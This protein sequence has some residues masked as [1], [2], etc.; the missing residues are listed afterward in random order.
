MGNN[1]SKPESGADAATKAP[2]L[3]RAEKK[4][5]AKAAK[6]APAAAA[7]ATTPATPAAPPPPPPPPVSKPPP[8]A[9]QPKPL[10]PS[11]N[12][13]G[14]DRYFGLENFGN[15]CYANSV[16]QALYFC[17]PFRAKVLEHAILLEAEAARLRRAR[18]AAR[19]HA[20]AEKERLEREAKLRP[21]TAEEK[22]AEKAAEKAEKER[23]AAAKAA[24]KAAKEAA[25][26]ADEE[27]DFS[28]PRGKDAALAAAEEE[29]A[30][31][32]KAKADAERS[33]IPLDENGFPDL[34]AEEKPK[35]KDLL[36]CLADV[37]S[38]I[39]FSKRR[40]GVVGPKRFVQRL[41][42]DN[43]LFRSYMHQDA[44]E[45]Y[46][47]LLE[48]SARCLEQRQ[49]R[50]EEEDRL[51]SR[52]DEQERRKAEERYAAAV[53]EH[54]RA[55]VEWRAAKEANKRQHKEALAKAQREYEASVE[56]HARAVQE[57]EAAVAAQ[58]AREAEHAAA[59]EAHAAAVAA[60]AEGAEAPPPPAPL[61]AVALPPPPGPAPAPF[62]PPPE[63]ARVPA[64]P[65][66][67]PPPPAPPDSIT[68]NGQA[69]G[70]VAGGG[71]QQDAANAPD[72]A[73]A[74]GDDA[75]TAPPPPPLPPLRKTWVHEIFEGS[76][77]SEMRC[78][79]C[80]TL[81][82]REEAFMDL[83]LEV[84][85]DC[86]VGGLLRRF[87]GVETMGGRDNKYAC[88]KCGCLQEAQKRLR[89]KRLP[90]VL[91]LHL[92]R[93]KVVDA[94]SGRM[95]KLMHRVVF[96]FELK[97]PMATPDAAMPPV[98][99]EDNA[100]ADDPAAL[101]AAIAAAAGPP[102]CAGP[103]AAYS[104][105]AIVV[106]VGSGPHHGHYVSLVKTEH[107]RWL[108]YDDDAV[109][110]V[111]DA[112][113]A[114]TF[115]S[116]TDDAPER[117]EQISS[118]SSNRAG[119]AGASSSSSAAAQRLPIPPA[120]PHMDHGYLLFYERVGL[121]HTPP[122][123]PVL[124]PLP[125]KFGGVLLPE[126]Q[127]ELRA[128]VKPASAAVVVGGRPEALAAAAAATGGR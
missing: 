40:T 69:T 76:T 31:L 97:L 41:K 60:L 90:P 24:A 46:L 1:S 84:E 38:E 120:P 79:R 14:G 18:D 45:F 65:A 17:A 80:E 6:D 91:V 62:V 58:A 98:A 63:P 123:A 125:G 37:Y 93:F 99:E 104:L 89:V 86:S 67:V 7:A 94:A 81:S 44:Q 92:K 52:W 8:P 73:A 64:P 47:F 70:A 72:N 109:D 78:L 126:Q 50:M 118:S 12:P 26:Y 22:A 82:T 117:G 71:E 87:S 112:A 124:K 106:H 4:A 39:A 127:A 102:P 56:A 77:V 57:Y 100:A 59:V 28:R 122:L 5:L 2:K 10:W 35:D 108:F 115:G 61:A 49:R 111:S 88:D 36:A 30:A 121:V 75:T 95:R 3:S 96:P 54:G 66:P 34:L 51:R 20:Q 9:V 119:G 33:A 43:E 74:N 83:S 116:P 110:V 32:A 85:A 53:E 29:A 21:K 15:T 114:A 113:V 23:K 25:R 48:A 55:M 16:L 27:P 128:G 105:V 68:A 107:G 11:G 103:D 101:A 19:A 42:K 13:P